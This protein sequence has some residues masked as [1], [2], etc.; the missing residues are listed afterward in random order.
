M[1]PD[2]LSCNLAVLCCYVGLATS[3]SIAHQRPDMRPLLQAVTPTRMLRIGCFV[4]Q[5][6]VGWFRNRTH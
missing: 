5:L 6:R 1:Q 4:L 2:K 3:E